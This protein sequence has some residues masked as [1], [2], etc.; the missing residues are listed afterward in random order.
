MKVSRAD[1]HGWHKDHPTGDYGFKYLLKGEPSSPDNFLWILGR[2]EGDF[3]M[4][5]HRHNFEQIRLPLCGSMNLGRGIVLEQ[6]QVG[7][8]PEGLP[9]GPQEDPLGDAQ[10]GERLQLVL[11]F[12]GASGYGFMSMEQRKLA[13]A[14]L[15]QTGKFV[16]PHYHRPDGT[17]QWGL[18]TVW[19]HVFGSKLRYPKPRYSEIIIADP[20]RFNWLP[21]AGAR[22]VAHKYMGAYTERAFWFE[23]LRLDTG[24]AWRSRDPA[25]RRL[26]YV[27]SGTGAIGGEEFVAGSAIEIDPGEEATMIANAPLELFLIGLPPVEVPTETSVALDGEE[28]DPPATVAEGQA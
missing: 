13:W 18:N 14:E 17:V 27:L 20:R 10:P 9:Y 1:Q 19:E 25:A 24:A 15:E 22:G 28:Y 7:Y 8:F 16:G 3:R 11:Q 26:F 23:M 12:G 5:R 21:L 2:Q 4:P 6:G